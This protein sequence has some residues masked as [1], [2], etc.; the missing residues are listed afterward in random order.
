ML[1]SWISYKQSCYF[2]ISLFTYLQSAINTNRVLRYFWISLFTE[3][4]ISL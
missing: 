4:F 2:W 1:N 3:R